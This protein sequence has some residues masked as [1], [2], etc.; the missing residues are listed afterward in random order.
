MSDDLQARF[1]K[2]AEEVTQ[3]SEAPDNLT[4]LK[5]Y[6]LFKQGSEGDVQGKRPGMMD[7]VA[8][9]KYD[10]WK[11]HEGKSKEQGME[12]YIALVEELKAADAA[13]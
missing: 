3:L 5:L 2:A 7:F 1:A 10:A 12:E 8:R 11:E 4:K 13:K 6:S 9:A